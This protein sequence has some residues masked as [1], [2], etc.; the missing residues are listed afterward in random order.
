MPVL[1][2]SGRPL[3]YDIYVNGVMVGGEGHRPEA[4]TGPERPV[5]AMGGWGSFGHGRVR[6]LPRAVTTGRTVVV[7]DWPGIGESD[8]D[9]GRP[10]STRSYAQDAASL[11]DHLGWSS[12]SVVGIVGMGGAVAQW[13]AVDRPDLV[14]RLVLSGTWARADQYFRD[15]MMLELRTFL[16]SGFEVFQVLT[17]TL[18]FDPAFYALNRDRIV[19]PAGAWSD[20]VDRPEALS[21]F[22]SACVDHD[23]LDRLVDIAAPTW[24]IHAGADLITGTRLTQ[25]LEKGIAGSRGVMIDDLPH[26]VAGKRAKM[27]FDR[28][29]AMAL[30]HDLA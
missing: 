30:E 16:D 20:L 26:V 13:L 12:V 5:L 10:A 19:G 14:E 6:D 8:L 21:R 11:L 1:N 17:A 7:F 25:V 28:V 9:S 29:I 27:A 24:V 4:G 22:V 18:S 15:Q 23:T 3:H 2:C